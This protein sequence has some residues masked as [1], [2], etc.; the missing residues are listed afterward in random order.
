VVDLVGTGDT[1]R[2]AGLEEI[3]TI[4]ETEAAFIMNPHSQHKDIAEKLTKRINGV[5]TAQ[6]YVIMEYNVEKTKL[7]QVLK[8]TP[9]V[10]S[11]TLSPLENKD[12]IAVK[13]MVAKQSSN[14]ILDELEIIGAKD[15]VVVTISNC[16]S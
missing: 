10:T 7:S 5:L 11:P 6:N 2:A 15:I 1:M 9:G 3:H 12:W 4:L 8:V 14:Q 13:V 16:R